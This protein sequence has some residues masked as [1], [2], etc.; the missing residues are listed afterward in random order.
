MLRRSRRVTAGHSPAR[1]GVG[2]GWAT[3]AASKWKEPD[4]V[5]IMPQQVLGAKTRPSTSRTPSMVTAVLGALAESGSTAAMKVKERPCTP[6]HI[7]PGRKTI[8]SM[9]ITSLAPLTPC[10][11]SF[12]SQPAADEGTLDDGSGSPQWLVC[13]LA[14][15]V[16][17]GVW[18]VCLRLAGDAGL[19]GWQVRAPS[20]FVLPRCCAQR[21]TIATDRVSA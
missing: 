2:D 9:F 20:R 12:P 15:L 14:A 19:K 4:T 17:Y 16:I 5:D 13:S 11:A 18:A 8:R 7:S 21:S 6:R 10:R 1:L 3:S